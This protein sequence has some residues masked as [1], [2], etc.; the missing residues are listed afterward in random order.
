MKISVTRSPPD[1]FPIHL[2]WQL[3]RETA[4]NSSGKIV[5][6]FW[7]REKRRNVNYPQWQNA[8]VKPPLG[9]NPQFVHPT[10]GEGFVKYVPYGS[11]RVWGETWGTASPIRNDGVWSFERALWGS[12]WA[13]ICI[14]IIPYK[15]QLTDHCWALPRNLHYNLK[16]ITPPVCFGV[17]S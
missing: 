16:L 8:T 6:L 10:E 5:E 13:I 9:C 3:L 12:L 17:F 1:L 11:R 7:R 15:K 2:I 4:I 14:M